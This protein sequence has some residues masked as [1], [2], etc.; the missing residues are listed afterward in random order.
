M[1]RGYC[2][3]DGGTLFDVPN[4]QHIS[5]K[6]PVELICQGCGSRYEIRHNP[7]TGVIYYR[8]A[9]ARASENIAAEQYG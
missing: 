2:P 4:F 1:Q 5:E 6:R 7:K 9:G 8:A 3:N